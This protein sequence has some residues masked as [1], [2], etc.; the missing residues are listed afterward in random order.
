MQDIVKFPKVARFEY[1]VEPFQ[2][3]CTGHL[4]W[5]ELGNKLLAVAGHHADDR[6]YGMKQLLP[7]HRAWVISRMAIEVGELPKVGDS[8]VLETWIRKVYYTFTDR[9]FAISK[10]DGTPLGYAFTIWALIDTET[11]TPVNLMHIY[12][13]KITDWVDAEKKC[14]V[15]PFSHI[16]VKTPEP[17]REIMACFS[18]IDIN[19]HVNS[20]KYVQHVLDVFPKSMFEA[21]RVRRVEM[22]Y[23]GEAH[24][25]ESLLFYKQQ[26]SP[27][28][29]D[30]DVRVPD[31]DGERK[32]CSCRVN[33]E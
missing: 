31:G 29:Y 7:E 16:R 9:C 2:E 30:I 12:D 25:G 33:F 21:R 13:G 20:I 3:D 10:P 24:Y 6:G 14:D 5:L 1:T 17:E 32:V 23:H 15:A 8:F 4:S 27:L 28:E 26:N 18:D 19:N 22:A 11:R